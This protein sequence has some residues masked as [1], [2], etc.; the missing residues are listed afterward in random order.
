MS[1]CYRT[2]SHI[3]DDSEELEEWLPELNDGKSKGGRQ[4]LK[5][6]TAET[7][8]VTKRVAKPKEPKPKAERKPRAVRTTK[9]KKEKP[10][11]EQQPED[12]NV[13]KPASQQLMT[14]KK[15]VCY[16]FLF[17]IFPCERC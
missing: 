14:V 1:P 11:T 3:K 6:G 10:S 12:A 13:P 15:E 17:Q 7:K 2:P 8:Q 4:R 16:S 9:A 5:D